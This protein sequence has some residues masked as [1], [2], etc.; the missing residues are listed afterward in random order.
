VLRGL[1]KLV[2]LEIKIFV[3]EPM[4]VFGTVGVPVLLFLFVNRV[5]GGAPRRA[6]RTLTDFLR[7]DLVVVVAVFITISAVL[8]LVTIISIYRESGIL[9]RLRATPLRPWTI[10]AAHVIVKLVFSGLTVALMVLAGRRYFPADADVPIVDFGLAVLLSTW[11]VLSV[12]FVIASL[13]PTARFAQLI[14][15]AVIYPMLP[16]C[17]LLFPIALL[18]P[19]LQTVA[20]WLPLTYAVS[21]LRGIWQ[22]EPW[23]AHTHDVAA[24][25][26]VFAVCTLLS[27]RLF[28]WE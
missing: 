5:G 8:S 3:R 9:K 11:S 26:T 24:L 28:R 13:V 22:G 1:L 21:L 12:G 20:A 16:F 7:L 2:W 18:P 17:G 6:A 15:A 27:S 19:P 25:V 14:G 23:L 10:L 4:G